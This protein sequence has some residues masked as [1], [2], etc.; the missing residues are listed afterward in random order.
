MSGT[1]LDGAQVRKLDKMPT[2]Q[3]LMQ[4]VAVMIKKVRPSSSH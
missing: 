1:Y 3:Q 4:A 2:K